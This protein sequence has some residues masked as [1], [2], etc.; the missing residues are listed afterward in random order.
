[1]RQTFFFGRIIEEYQVLI[2][3][4]LSQDAVD[5]VNIQNLQITLQLRFFVS[6]IHIGPALEEIAIETIDEIGIVAAVG[7][8]SGT[9]GAS[10]H[11]GFYAFEF[12]FGEAKTFSFF[13]FFHHGIEALQRFTVFGSGTDNESIHHRVDRIEAHFGTQERRIGLAGN[14]AQTFSKDGVDNVL[15]QVYQVAHAVSAIF[16]GQRFRLHIHAQFGATCFRIGDDTHDRFNIFGN[17][18]H[19]L[20]LSILAGRNVGKQSFQFAFDNIHID[21]AH[22]DNGLQIGT[23]PSFVESLQFF[24]GESFQTLFC[25]ND[26]G[27]GI[28]RTLVKITPSLFHH[29]PTSIATRTPFFDDNTS[30]LI[31]FGRIV[32]NKSRVI[33][34]NEQRSIDDTFT[35]GRNV[36]EHIH[37]LFHA[38]GSI[39][40]AS[41]FS[42]YALEIIQHH[43]AGQILGAVQG[44]VFQ[45]VSQTILRR[46]FLNGAHVGKQVILSSVGRFLIVTDV[47]SQSIVQ[48]AI[49][50]GRIF[51]HGR[52]RINLRHGDGCHQKG[53]QG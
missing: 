39:D 32:G 37:G 20:G 30:F 43:F 8:G 45:E 25:T 12:G 34:Q 1:M 3:F 29:T 28:F 14:V 27:G 51:H 50:H 52:L 2:Q 15:H 21:V 18:M 17:L 11:V 48:L 36:V 42:T 4:H 35:D 22:N 47:V 40:V 19:F 24:C 16:H 31:D 33:V 46:A 49:T 41:E 7:V 38:G 9:F 44:H 13:E 23:I 5:L 10:N 26:I 53:N 6:G